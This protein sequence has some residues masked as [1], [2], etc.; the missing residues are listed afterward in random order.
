[1]KG[2]PQELLDRH[3]GGDA[4][5]GPALCRR[6]LPAVRGL[7]LAGTMDAEHAATVA[8]DALGRLLDRLDEVEESARAIT[9]VEEE[10]REAL[11]RFVR[12]HGS[13]STELVGIPADVAARAAGPKLDLPSLFEEVPPEKSAW[14]LLEGATYLPDKYET[15]FLLRY[16]EGMGYQE[17]GELVGQSAREVG[18]TVAAARRLYDRELGFHLRKIAGS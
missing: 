12:E 13:R 17:I 14:M 1:V 18:N 5:A 11:L 10:T 7:A 6:Y 4:R 16:L 2:N 9:V 15:V 3:H 8:K